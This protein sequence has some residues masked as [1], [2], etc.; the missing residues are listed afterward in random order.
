MKKVLSVAVLML[1]FIFMGVSQSN[2]ESSMG[3]MLGQK[4]LTDTNNW[5][6]SEMNI[7]LSD[8]TEFGIEFN[9]GSAN[10]ELVIGLMVGKSND[11]QSFMISNYYYSYDAY[12]K[13]ELYTLETR[14][15]YRHLFDI[16][17]SIHPYIG[18]GI[19]YT[20]AKATLTIEIPGYGSESA[21]IYGSGFGYYIGGGVRYDISNSVFLGV[22]ISK[23]K[24][25]ITVDVEDYGFDVDAG[26]THAL[27]VIGF[28]F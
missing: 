21:D 19:A 16:T 23:S 24:A 12:V 1:G 3:L 9:D 18:G 22:D 4:T 17:P 13:E 20:T 15:G 14:I 25:D 27:A 6:D 26:G 10:D 5:D 28:K 11:K 8:Q 2:A 7:N